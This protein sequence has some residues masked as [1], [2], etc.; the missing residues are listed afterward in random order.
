MVQFN[1]LP[2]VKLE[3]IRARQ[4]K[5]LM[6]LVSVAVSAASLVVLIIMLLTVYVV[7]KKS[8][9]DVNHDI[10]RY[11]NQLK[12][13]PDLNKILTVQHQLN[14]LTALHDQKV[15]ASRLFGYLA[16]VTPAQA[17]LNKLTVDFTQNTITI[18]GGAPSLDTV[19]VY[20][21]TLKSTTYTANGNAP[22]HA[23]SNV[24]L[25]SFGRNTSGAT[26]TITLSFDPIIFQE[27]TNAKLAVPA[28]SSTDQAQLFGKVGP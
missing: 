12:N 13:T 2:D 1:L 4:L 11:G 25:S 21:D 19:S 14:S 20:T 6:T 15:V 8:L 27:N 7:Q 5:R 23:F 10:S 26:F 3:Y 9:N 17:A 16:Q 28:G 22:A 24:V 18:G